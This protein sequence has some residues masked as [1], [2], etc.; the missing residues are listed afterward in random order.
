MQAALSSNIC[1]G[2][3]VDNENPQVFWIWWITDLSQMHSR[4]A[5]W[6]AMIS[7]WLDDVATKV[8]FVER[9]DIVVPLYVK[10]YPVCERALWGSDRYPAS[11]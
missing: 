9:H 11:A 2:I 3:S 5:S 8:C 1:V 4:L 7:E 6:S 10:T